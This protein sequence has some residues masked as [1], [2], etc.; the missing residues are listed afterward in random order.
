VGKP[1]GKYE[2]EHLYKKRKDSNAIMLSTAQA[3]DLLLKGIVP[4]GGAALCKFCRKNAEAYK[5]GGEEELKRLRCRSSGPTK[6]I[7]NDQIKID[8]KALEK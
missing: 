4:E 7:T 3:T 2:C 8:Y 1:Q 6:L 5:E